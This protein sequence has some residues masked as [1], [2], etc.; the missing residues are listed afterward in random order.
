L[1][2]KTNYFIGISK[3]LYRSIFRK[4]NHFFSTLAFAEKTGKMNQQEENRLFERINK[5]DEKAFEILFHQYY[6]ILCSFAT[7][8]IHDDVA[9]EEIVQDLY[10]KLW[11]K[12]EQIS[13]ETS[14]KN[15]FFRSVKNLC[16]NFIQHNKTKIAHAQKL[17][18]EMENNFSDDNSYPEPD[19]YEKIEESINSLPEKR[20]EI[21]RL[22]RQE[23]L[24]YQEIAQKL[25]ISIKTVETQMSLAIK[26]LRDK[27]KNYTTFFSFF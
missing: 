3:I 15:Y 4:E 24:K 12:R 23:G 2:R 13:I 6:G 21:F 14:V 16:L 26:T 27:L 8:L 18:S 17:L 10:V 7:K 9:A 11:E 20:R 19:L 5:S 1:V 22:S 25:N